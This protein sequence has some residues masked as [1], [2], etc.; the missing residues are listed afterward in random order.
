MRDDIR[1]S[2]ISADVVD[3]RFGRPTKATIAFS[4]SYD[5]RSPDLA[6]KVANELTTLYLNENL[7]NRRQLADDATPF[8][9]A[10][11]DR[12]SKQIAELDEKLAAVQGA[13]RRTAAGAE[14]S[15]ICS[16][17]VAGPRRSCARPTRACARSTSRSSISKRSSRS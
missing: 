15:S 16:C 10:E 8:L 3:P 5:N 1:F 11:A 2:M 13:Q 9:T 7:E 17:I 14:R 4:V 12:L 6:A